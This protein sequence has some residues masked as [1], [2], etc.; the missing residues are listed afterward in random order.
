[1]HA[2]DASSSGRSLDSAP[3]THRPRVPAT[4][5]QAPARRLTAY[6]LGRSQ[7]VVVRSSSSVMSSAPTS[8]AGA[9]ADDADGASVGEAPHATRRSDVATQAVGLRRGEGIFGV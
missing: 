5:A 9:T 8:P 2:V 6:C 3:G 1:M 4:S 7:D